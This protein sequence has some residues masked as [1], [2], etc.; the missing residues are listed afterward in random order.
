[1]NGDSEDRNFIIVNRAGKAKGKYGNCQNVK[2]KES[3]EMS[4]INF[5]KVNWSNSDNNNNQGMHGENI[6][7]VV[8]RETAENNDNE[9]KLGES[10]QVVELIFVSNEAAEV[11]KEEIHKAKLKELSD[12]KS[13]DVYKTVKDIGQ[14]QISTRWIISKKIKNEQVITKA[15]LVARGFEE[16]QV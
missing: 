12:W 2:D 5:D 7:E 15:R 14:K 4:Y 1:M 8:E 11:Q 13:H 16:I 6:E 3:G 10:S 9:E